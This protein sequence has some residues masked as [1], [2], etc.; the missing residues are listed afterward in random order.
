[1]PRH[2]DFSAAEITKFEAKMKNFDVLKYI[3]DK[4]EQHRKE[5]YTEDSAWHI[6]TAEAEKDLGRFGLYVLMVLERIGYITTTYTKPIRKVYIKP[7]TR[8]KSIRRIQFYRKAKRF[9]AKIFSMK[10]KNNGK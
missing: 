5:G 3:W 8:I 2:E 4:K 10:I 6:T 7:K 9:M 1:M